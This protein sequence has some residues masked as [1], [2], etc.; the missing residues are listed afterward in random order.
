M[1]KIIFASIL[2]ATLLH[3]PS[4]A[5]GI[6]TIDPVSIS[7]DMTNFILQTM[8]DLE[9]HVEKYKVMVQQYQNMIAQ[10]E[11]MKNQYSGLISS[12][13]DLNNMQ[14]LYNQALTNYKKAIDSYN[15][16]AEVFN[17]TFSENC[18]SHECSKD[19]IAAIEKLNQSIETIK[20]DQDPNKENSTA[21]AM[22]EH[23]DKFIEHLEEVEKRTQDQDSKEGQILKDIRF[24]LQTMN[25]QL[26]MS[27]LEANKIRTELEHQRLARE[28]DDAERKV[29]NEKQRKILQKEQEE[30]RAYLE[31]K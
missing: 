4:Y 31:I 20:N 17:K 22:Q 11:F 15:S 30:F 25:N 16:Y 21:K 27:Q 1:K 8:N 10:Y 23:N 19:T 29:F 7:Q 26:I 12:P 14:N 24:N 18:T 5:G 9:Q 3:Q 13:L 2:S 6:P 28:K